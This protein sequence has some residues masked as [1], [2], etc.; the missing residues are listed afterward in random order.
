MSSSACIY[1][2]RSNVSFN[3]EHVIPEAFG[4]YGSDTPVLKQHVCMTCN[5][6]LGKTLDQVLARDSYEGLIRSQTLPAKRGQRDRFRSRRVELR[7]PDK[8]E[9][10]VLR[11]ARVRMDWSDRLPLLLDQV[12]VRTATNELRSY[13]AQEL[14]GAPDITFEG[15]PPNAMRVVGLDTAEVGKLV[16]LA[17][18]RGARLE[19]CPGLMPVPASANE[20]KVILETMG[21]INDA[22]WRSIAKIAFNYLAWIQGSAYVLADRFDLIRSFILEPNQQRALVRLVQQPILA[23]ESRKWKCFSGHLVLFE[24]SGRCLVAKV[25]LFNSITYQIVLS[26]D[27]EFYYSLSIG[28]SFDPVRHEVHKLTSIPNRIIVPRTHL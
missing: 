8:E 9:F 28:H 7:F 4:T 18:A 27:L 1:C 23:N 19:K 26:H 3:R 22:V 25:S 6:T 16:E 2:K 10:G 5:S 20:P 12:M 15:L 21:V 14:E 13:T 24:T 11:G 17:R